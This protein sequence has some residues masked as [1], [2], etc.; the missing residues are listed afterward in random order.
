MKEINEDTWSILASKGITVNV[1][2]IHFVYTFGLR[3]EDKK[4]LKFEDVKMSIILQ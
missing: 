1:L 4:L 3:K 2:L